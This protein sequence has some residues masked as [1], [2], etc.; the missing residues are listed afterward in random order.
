MFV[1]L[2]VC[3]GCFTS[4]A[5]NICY[6]CHDDIQIIERRG[7]L[8]NDGKS[9]S[10]HLKMRRDYCRDPFRIWKGSVEEEKTYVYPLASPG[11]NAD[12]MRFSI[13][14][15]N[16]RVRMVS[17]EVKDGKEV[18]DNFHVKNV[19]YNKLIL[20]VYDR[21]VYDGYEKELVIGIDPNDLPF[22]SRPYIIRG[23]GI[24]FS[25]KLVIPYKQEDNVYHVYLPR[26]DFITPLQIMNKPNTSTYIL[27]FILTPPAI[28]L[29]ILTGPLQFI[30]AAPFYLG[31]NW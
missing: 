17:F 5:N 8:S 22:L 2:M 16:W 15:D 18:E 24:N 6:R 7:E 30:L 4:I 1:L 14:S 19:D 13:Y 23:W 9:F 28:C 21:H 31:Y 29:D 10:I 25:Y 27:G 20:P 26:T 12:R 11:P 3:N